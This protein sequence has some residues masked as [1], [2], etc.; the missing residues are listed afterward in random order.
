M[1]VVVSLTDK[2]ALK[3]SKAFAK[4]KDPLLVKN[5]SVNKNFSNN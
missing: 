5:V 1:G 2:L 3:I 4:F